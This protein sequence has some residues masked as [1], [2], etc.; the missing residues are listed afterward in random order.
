M[1]YAHQATD[2]GWYE[3]VVVE[4]N[5]DECVVRY[6]EV[7]NPHFLYYSGYLTFSYTTMCI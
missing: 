5:E 6:T 3:A 2:Q 7:F 4:V 1:Y